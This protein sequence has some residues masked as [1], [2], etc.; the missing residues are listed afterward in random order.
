MMKLTYM[1]RGT[2]A[3]TQAKSTK[4]RRLAFSSESA[5]ES[6]GGMAV[7]SILLKREPEVALV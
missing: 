3:N 5:L 1:K 2:S 4:R 7:T 6:C